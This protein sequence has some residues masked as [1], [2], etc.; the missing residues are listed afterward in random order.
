MAAGS[1]H[2]SLPALRLLSE[3]RYSEAAAA[4]PDMIISMSNMA[5]GSARPI[6]VLLT[7]LVH[8]KWCRFNGFLSSL[9]ANQA[10]IGRSPRIRVRFG[11]FRMAFWLLL[12]RLGPLV[13]R[14]LCTVG[15]KP[16]ASET[17]SGG[18]TEM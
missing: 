17:L 16:V 2:D 6:H 11:H 15:I 1:E 9:S 14:N 13:L 18:L 8:T 10:Q 3:S 4:R 12:A 5:T 7:V